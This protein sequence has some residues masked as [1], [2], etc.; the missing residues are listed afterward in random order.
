[1]GAAPKAFITYSHNDKEERKE[2]RTRLLVMENNGEIELWDDNEILPGDEWYNDIADNLS[3]SDIL[4]YLVSAASLASKN[5][6]KELAEALRT[7]TRVIP[8]ILE[9]CDWLNHELSRFEVLPD[10]GK[11]I[12]TWEPESEG[13]QNVVEGARAVI[14]KIRGREDSATRTSERELRA[15]LAFQQG[16]FLLILGHTDEAIE[17]YSYA[18]KLNPHHTDAYSNRGI[19][20][21][22]N[23]ERDLAIEDFNKQIQLEPN[24][25]KGYFYASGA[26]YDRGI[27]HCSQGN[28]DLAIEDYTKAIEL[29]P[30]HA[31]AYFDSRC[32]LQR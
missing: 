4:L 3:N 12:N 29:Q 15:E 6:N 18:I 11:P 17:A 22:D 5:C 10:K 27:L 28:D 31:D 19:A 8:I 26:Y 30:D 21:L 14:H 1:M 9:A 32:Y 13:W 24:S 23:E 20:Y 16:N 7:D 2:L 25:V